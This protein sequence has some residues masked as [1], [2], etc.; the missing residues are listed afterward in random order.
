VVLSYIFHHDPRKEHE[1]LVT[2]VS[3]C[4]KPDATILH[5][6]RDR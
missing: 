6:R 1:G 2:L 3:L 5:T 4:F